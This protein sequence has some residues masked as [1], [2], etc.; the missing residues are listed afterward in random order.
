MDAA[1]K[2]VLITDGV[3]EKDGIYGKTSSALKCIWD[4]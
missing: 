2:G 1:L 4:R 3:Y